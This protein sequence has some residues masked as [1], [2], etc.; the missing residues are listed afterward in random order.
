MIRVELGGNGRN[1]I[2]GQNGIFD[3]SVEGYGVE[4][5]SR[6]PLLDACRAVKS[7]GADT[8]AQIG[9]FWHG[10]D[11]PSL[12]CTVE[13]GAALTVDENGPCFRLW[14]PFPMSP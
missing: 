9:L 3:Y 2:N 13:A 8:G 10:S 12:I 11:H 14:R 4:G 5:R 1:G 6:K 7:M